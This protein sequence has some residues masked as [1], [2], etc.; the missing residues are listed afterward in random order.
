MIHLF[1]KIRHKLLSESKFGRYLTYAIGEI[2]LVVIGIL[3]AL[4][5]N[6]W[7]ET[8]KIRSAEQEILQNLKVELLVNQDR[9]EQI[10]TNQFKDIHAGDTLLKLFHTDITNVSISKL[11]SILA[12]FE[13]TITFE[14]SD[15]YITSL[16]ASGNIDYIQNS[17]IKSFVGSFEGEVVDA[18]EEINPM[19]RLFEERLWPTI[20][21]KI[22]SSNRIRNLK[23][24]ASFPKGSY[25]SDYVWFFKNREI[26]DIISNIMAWKVD[27]MQD[28]LSLL[29]NIE[30]VIKIIE[31]EMN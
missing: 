13:M 30:K 4:S 1:R 18:T 15:G 28:E 10:Y 26:E 5:I 24:Y 20:D 22:N 8:R 11:D 31:G 25:T 6:N 7:N 23:T 21:G 12:N 29:N 2:I 3:I 16:L 17:A 19:K 27:L 9:L 14:A